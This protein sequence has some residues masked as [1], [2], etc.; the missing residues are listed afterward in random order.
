MRAILYRQSRAPAPVRTANPGVARPE[1]RSRVLARRCARSRRRE[2]GTGCHVAV[3]R[4]PGDTRSSDDL[5]HGLAE[6]AEV[7]GVRELLG[8]DHR[9]AA[10]LAPLRN[11]DCTGVS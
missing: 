11:R 7:L 8:V 5:A 10:G 2:F 9:L 6:V 3:E 4:G 1:G